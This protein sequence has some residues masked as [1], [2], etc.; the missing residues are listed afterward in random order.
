MRPILESDKEYRWWLFQETEP[1]DGYFLNQYI[2]WEQAYP[3]PAATVTRK[4]KR[5]KLSRTAL[6]KRLYRN[7]VPKPLWPE[8]LKRYAGRSIFRSIDEPTIREQWGY[9]IDK[10]VTRHVNVIIMV[11]DEYHTYAQPGIANIFREARRFNIATTLVTQSLADFAEPG[12]QIQ[13]FKEL[14]EAILE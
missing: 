3:Q 12:K 9:A 2:R 8:L 11:C 7:H 1:A 13:R 5:S 14:S 4:P 10:A 6:R